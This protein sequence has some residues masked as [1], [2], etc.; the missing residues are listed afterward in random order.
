MCCPLMSP[1]GEVVAYPG[2]LIVSRGKNVTT[3]FLWALCLNVVLDIFS[4]L[5]SSS[6]QILSRL[7]TMENLQVICEKIESELRAKHTT[8]ENHQMIAPTES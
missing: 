7:Q 1:K 8:T 2:N 5:G 6:I 3:C 4:I